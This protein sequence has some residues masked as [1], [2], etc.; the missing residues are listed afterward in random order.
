[1]RAIILIASV[2]VLGFLLGQ[3]AAAPAWAADARPLADEQCVLKCDRQSDQC[4]ARA[5]RDEQKAKACDDQYAECL[6]K[7]R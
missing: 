6:K 2:M 5:G 3:R 7:C 1:M 4:M